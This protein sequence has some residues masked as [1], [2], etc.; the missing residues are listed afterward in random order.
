M[1]SRG[2]FDSVIWGCLLGLVGCGDVPAQKVDQTASQQA[3]SNQESTLRTG[4]NVQYENKVSEADAITFAQ[5]LI[6][7]ARKIKEDTEIYDLEAVLARSLDGIDP[8][9]KK[10]L[11]EGTTNGLKSGAFVR[12]FQADTENGGSARL[13]RVR[14]QK[15][16]TTVLIRIV[17][18][19]GRHYYQ[20]YALHKDRNGAVKAIDSRSMPPNEWMTDATNRDLKFMVKSL[21][22]LSPEQQQ[23][24]NAVQ[25]SEMGKVQEFQRITLS[26]DWE[27]VRKVYDQLPKTVQLHRMHLQSRFAAATHLNRWDD[28]KETVELMRSLE[29]NDPWYQYNAAEVCVHDGDYVGA[30]KALQVINE[31]A[32]GDAELHSRM[33]DDYLLAGDKT[34]ARHEYERALEIEP[35]HAR[36]QWALVKFG[37]DNDDFP[38][39]LRHLGDL[40]RLK[41]VRFD[42]LEANESF[43]S[44]VT[45]PT[46]LDWKSKLPK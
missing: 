10:S 20:E 28:A 36:T 16:L 8:R 4:L 13:L 21:L 17:A 6:S 30:I 35:T 1:R 43:Q 19:D 40:E 9:F 41:Q 2:R 38:L 29:P 44:L 24:K 23:N 12:R 39:A 37:V 18:G 32:G 31:W 34:A 45:D 26:Q 7:D 15:G 5:N 42:E 46:Y 33:G 11:S 3:A 27:S 22:A 25:I 14:E